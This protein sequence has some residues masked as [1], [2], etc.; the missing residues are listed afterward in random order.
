M[1]QKQ[2]NP[3]CSPTLKWRG[4]FGLL[5]G[6]RTL[7][8][9]LGIAF[10]F[11][12]HVATATAAPDFPALTGRVVDEAE[13][14]SAAVETEISASL[15]AHEQAFGHQV[16]VVTLQSLR[17]Y[18]ISDYGLQL[19]RH[20]GVGQEGKNDGVLLIVAP[21]QREMRIEVIMPLIVITSLLST[22]PGPFSLSDFTICL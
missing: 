12:G 3:P 9:I 4:L 17:D 10:I 22:C 19:G 21:N 16:V 6:V 8:G 14:L 15:A 7:P 5:H 20:W 18:T 2:A 1:L 13:I 11:C